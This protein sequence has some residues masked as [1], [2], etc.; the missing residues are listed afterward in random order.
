VGILIP[1][2]N[3]TMFIWCDYRIIQACTVSL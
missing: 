1:L 3:Y 2:A